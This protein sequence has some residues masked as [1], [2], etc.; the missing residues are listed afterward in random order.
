MDNVSYVKTLIEGDLNNISIKHF[1]RFIK[2][3][4]QDKINVNYKNKDGKTPLHIACYFRDKKL[5][6]IL[7]NKNANP[8]ITDN[9]G[10]IPLHTACGAKFAELTLHN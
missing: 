4:E 7:L 8:N 1:K 5:I 9:I 2:Y 3:I 6:S 10:K